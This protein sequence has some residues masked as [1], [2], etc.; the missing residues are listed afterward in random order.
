MAEGR[1]SRHS[2][3]SMTPPP[4][5]ASSS[6]KPILKLEENLSNGLGTGS[7]VKEEHADEERPVKLEV[8]DEA[9]VKQD[10]TNPNVKSENVQSGAA[11]AE[12]EERKLELEDV[13]MDGDTT[14]EEDVIVVQDE[15]EIAKA[16]ERH[17]ADLKHHHYE[18]PQAERVQDE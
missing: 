13:D 2:T 18:P 3:V 6:T 1:S 4:P 17:Q 8:K 11:K 16:K 14:R 9:K 7:G 10:T 5:E 15:K 12:R